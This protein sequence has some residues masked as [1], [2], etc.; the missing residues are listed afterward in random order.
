MVDRTESCGI[1]SIHKHVS[2]KINLPLYIF[3]PTS[4][5]DLSL[6]VVPTHP[7]LSLVFYDTRPFPCNDLFFVSSNLPSPNYPPF[8]PN[9]LVFFLPFFYFLVAVCNSLIIL[10]EFQEGKIHS[11]SP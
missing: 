10:L 7:G 11:V 9:M 6:F 5:S 2:C 4:G 1:Q 3:S 8:P